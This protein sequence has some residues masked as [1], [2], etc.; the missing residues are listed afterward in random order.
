[1]SRSTS[2]GTVESPHSTRCLPSDHDARLLVQVG[3][4]SGDVRS[5]DNH[6][7]DKLRQLR[8]RRK[9][10]TMKNIRH[11]LVLVAVVALV[12]L[13]APSLSSTAGAATVTTRQL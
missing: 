11:S 3:V 6:L 1:M 7:V 5:A 13:A 12:T 2:A 8:R 9:W 4:L 10:W